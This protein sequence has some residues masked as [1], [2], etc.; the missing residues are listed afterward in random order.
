MKPRPRIRKTLKWGGAVLSALLL[1]AWVGSGAWEQY[2]PLGPSHFLRLGHGRVEAGTSRIIVI[3]PNDTVTQ[4]MRIGTLM[5]APRPAGL[6]WWFSW[7]R[8]SSSWQLGVPLWVPAGVFLLVTATAWRL[9]TL[10]RRRA[11]IGLCP[12]CNYDRTG[13][14]PG[15]LCPECGAP[16]LAT[17]PAAS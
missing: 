15:A 3:D 9:D 14:A 8:S 13:L 11:R 10:A 16:A 17:P 1:V 5:P 6:R 4:A 2:A 12:N 7:N